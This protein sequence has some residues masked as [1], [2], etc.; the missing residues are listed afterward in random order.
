MDYSR[1]SH[2]LPARFILA[3]LGILANWIAYAAWVNLAR[4]F[5]LAGR[6][7]I[8]AF[9][10]LELW[11]YQTAYGAAGCLG[12]PGELGRTI[13]LGGFYSVGR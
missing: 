1:E 4:W 12:Y 5:I 13:G 2:Y 10:I 3:G 7:R 9:V 8:V 6:M 11:R